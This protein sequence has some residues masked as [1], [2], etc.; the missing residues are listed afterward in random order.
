MSG[1]DLKLEPK[2]SPVRRIEVITG[3]GGRRIWSD[4]DKA[5]II[6][7]AAA[8]GIVVSEVARRHGLTPQQLF[9]W[10]RQARRAAGA[11]RNLAPPFVPA[12][13][14][15]PPASTLPESPARRS[16][17][18]RR[19]AGRGTASGSAASIEFEIGG[20]TVRVGRDAE[21]ETIAA[22]IRALKAGA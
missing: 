4:G 17:S 16:A 9:T 5:R 11:I 18:P 21:T 22:V 8:P 12:V 7:E 3:A 14:E 20:V 10:L 15:L 2:A 13:I 1:L 19:R 6:E